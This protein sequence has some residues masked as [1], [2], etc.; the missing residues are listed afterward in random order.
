MLSRNSEG[1]FPLLNLYFLEI[2]FCLSYYWIV[3]FPIMYARIKTVGY[4]QVLQPQDSMFD[5][6]CILI[7]PLFIILI[8]EGLMMLDFFFPIHVYTRKG[9]LI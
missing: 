3:F 2:K 1:N 6:V 7:Q 4:F 8:N 9:T 5:T